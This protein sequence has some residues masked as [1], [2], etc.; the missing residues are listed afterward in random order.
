VVRST[1]LKRST[2]REQEFYDDL[3]SSVLRHN[4]FLDA[5]RSVDG[6][7][8]MA[9]SARAGR[10]PVTRVAAVNK[11]RFASANHTSL[12]KALQLASRPGTQIKFPMSARQDAGGRTNA[13]CTRNQRC[14][15][16]RDPLRGGASS[17]TFRGLLV[18]RSN[19]REGSPAYCDEPSNRGNA[20]QS[21]PGAWPYGPTPSKGTQ[22]I[23]AQWSLSFAQREARFYSERFYPAGTADVK[24]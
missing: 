21:Q 22:A 12:T 4:A 8:V 7:F 10:S 1:Y 14:P 9:S 23:L 11:R 13:G 15:V 2:S 20:C 6:I 3:T 18:K 16:G 19:E 24:S 17:S 5:V